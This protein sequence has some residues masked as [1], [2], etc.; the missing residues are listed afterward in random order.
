MN[1]ADFR[2]P[3]RIAMACLAAAVA[4]SSASAT[5]YFEEE[6]VCPIGGEKFKAKVIASTSTFG[7][8]A[9]G[10]P[11][12]GVANWPIPEC[13][14]NGLP[15]FKDDFTPEEIAVLRVAIATD[16]FKAMRVHDTAR[17]RLYWLLGELGTPIAN[18]IGSLY[19]ATWQ[20]DSDQE[21]KIRYQ[22]QFIEAATGWE[23]PGDD[24]ADAQDSWFWMNM[25]AVNALR[26]LGYFETGLDRLRVV[27]QPG[28]LPKEEDAASSARL[29]ASML[30]PLL[31]EKNPHP[32]PTNITPAHQAK[33]RC[34][35]GY[36][37]TAIE[38]EACSAV[39]VQEAIME[40]RFKS[41]GGKNLK[42]D[43]AVRAAV[44][45]WQSGG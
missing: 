27:M 4:V 22:A 8:R 26:E 31:L 17:Y 16:E 33:F 14:S 25:R 38:R 41:K 13:P 5:T 42:G 1:C 36:G 29:Y 7:Q 9:D 19:R 24:D 32:E 23:R 43:E 21:R 30:E 12:G 2:H 44:A 11:Y 15:L 34:V 28:H 6:F 3:A 45:Q 37:L 39:D 20:S 18:R 10:R 35:T 40:F